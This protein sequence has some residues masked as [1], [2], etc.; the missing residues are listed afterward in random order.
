MA[1][2]SFSVTGMTCEHCEAA[3]REE[4]GEVPGVTEV[5]V[6]RHDG[7]LMVTAH[8]GLT[9]NAVVTAVAEAGYSATP[10]G[11]P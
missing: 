9:T 1:Q 7:R 2:Y 8:E 6:N 3:I 4:V 5:D 10:T 11:Q